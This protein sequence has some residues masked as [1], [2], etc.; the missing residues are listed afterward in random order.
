VIT[1]LQDDQPTAEARVREF[2]RTLYPTLGH[3]IPM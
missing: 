2:A 3:H 1:P